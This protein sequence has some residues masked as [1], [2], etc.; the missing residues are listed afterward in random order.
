MSVVPSI[1]ELDVAWL[2]RHLDLVGATDLEVTSVGQG[3]VANCYR[4][5]I[6]HDAGT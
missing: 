5:R 3:Q 4:L 2:S 6:H 1:D